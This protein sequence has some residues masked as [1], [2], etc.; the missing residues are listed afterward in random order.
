MINDVR[1][2]AA[3]GSREPSPAVSAVPPSVPSAFDAEIEAIFAAYKALSS[4]S[5]EGQA[6]GLEWIRA[7][8]GWEHRICGD[9]A[10]S[11][12]AVARRIEM[13]I[14]REKRRLASSRPDARP[15]LAP[16]PNQ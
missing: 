5:P 3:P 8:L 15:C 4:I 16:D 10:M 1:L 11:L 6:R 13:A 12:S 7:R 2:P 14:N 9:M